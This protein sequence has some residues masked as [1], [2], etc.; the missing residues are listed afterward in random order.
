[1]MKDRHGHG[2]IIYSKEELFR[3]LREHGTDG[4][5]DIDVAELLLYFC[6]Y[7]SGVHELAQ[8]LIGERGSLANVF[9]AGV[10]ALRKTGLS[11]SAAVLMD[12][13]YEM[14]PRYA[15]AERG[16]SSRIIDTDGLKNMFRLYF[17]GKKTEE[18]HI[19]A[20]GEDLSIKAMK[21]LSG[22]SP[23]QIDLNTREVIEFLI[24][25]DAYM[26][27]M[28][29]NHPNAGCMP[30][31]EDR[32]LT[33]KIYEITSETGIIFADHII[34]GARN[35]YSFRENGELPVF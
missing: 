15:A 33:A 30:S 23:R 12:M 3:Q 35:C 10:P 6:G 16:E 8:T 26:T 7:R 20:F 5:S 14:Y 13:I 1:M 9:S 22:N 31:R 21:R 27:A 32:L 2:D 29:H 19:A 18:F 34:V 4:M 11:E 17:I 25:S 24:S 28:A